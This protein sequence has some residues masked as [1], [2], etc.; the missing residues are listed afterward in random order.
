MR[1]KIAAVK[2]HTFDKIN[3]GIEAL[4]FFD[5]DNAVFADTLECL[6]HYLADFNI[7]IGR[8]G[9]DIDDVVLLGNVDG[10]CQCGK[11]FDDGLD[12]Q[13]ASRD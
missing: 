10:L 6:A 2:L 8:Y 13:S 12:G 5:R 4:A 11:L 7:V 9:G 3:G 1:R